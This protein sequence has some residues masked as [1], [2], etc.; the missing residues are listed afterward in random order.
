MHMCVLCIYIYIYIYT[1]IYI[2]VDICIER[3]IDISLDGS[4]GET[5]GCASSLPPCSL[6]RSFAL[7][8]SLFLSFSPSLCPYLCRSLA[9]YLSLS[10][11]RSLSLSDLHV[12]GG[13]RGDAPLASRGLDAFVAERH[14]GGHLREVSSLHGGRDPLRFQ[15]DQIK[16]VVTPV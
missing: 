13:A 11:A 6:L 8:L 14:R 10:R 1:Y 7:S 5:R 4:G 9:L 12:D 3:W 16:E 15:A 2:Y